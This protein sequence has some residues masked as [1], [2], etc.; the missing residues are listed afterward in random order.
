MGNHDNFANAL[1]D[2]LVAAE[3]YNKSMADI[4]STITFLILFLPEHDGKIKWHSIE[5]IIYLVELI[6]ILIRLLVSLENVS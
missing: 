1:V 3:K 5:A 4:V 2:A 6:R